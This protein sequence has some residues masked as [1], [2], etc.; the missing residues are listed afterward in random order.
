MFFILVLLLCT[1]IIGIEKITSTLEEVDDPPK[2]IDWT[3]P[4]NRVS[5]YLGAK[6]EYEFFHI[7]E[8]DGTYNVKVRAIN[9]LGGI[10]EW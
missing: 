9:I 7:W 2:D 10:S 3:F 4:S 8:N 5:Y 6:Q 1:A